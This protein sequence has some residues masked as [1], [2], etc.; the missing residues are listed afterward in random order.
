MYA[1]V[2]AKIISQRFN[3]MKADGMKFA[4]FFTDFYM[5]CGIEPLVDYSYDLEK[6]GASILAW[7]WQKSSVN[8]IGDNTNSSVN[9]IVDNTNTRDDAK[10]DK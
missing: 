9:N 8:N 2:H 1:H 4:K 7:A 10:D 6:I 5:G 3:E